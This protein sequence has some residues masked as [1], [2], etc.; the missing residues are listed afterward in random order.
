[1]RES[2][3][4][5]PI[6][7]IS[8]RNAFRDLHM[9]IAQHRAMFDEYVEQ[10]IE[11]KIHQFITNELPNLLD[12]EIRRTFMEQLR[13]AISSPLFADQI[14]KAVGE[15]LYNLV[16][17]YK[18]D[19]VDYDLKKRIENI[20]KNTKEYKMISAILQSME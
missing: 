11:P 17:E 20:G 18:N 12:A 7:E 3:R 13:I 2:I 16:N 8:L 6:I 4:D 14:K 5:M 19:E 9:N 15:K 10:N 1:M